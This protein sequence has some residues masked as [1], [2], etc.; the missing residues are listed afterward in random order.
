[1]SKIISFGKSDK[2]LK[3]SNNEDS[4]V[5]KPDIS[6][7]AVADGMGGAASGEVASRIFSETIIEVFSRAKALSERDS[8]DLI[9]NTFRLANEKILSAVKENPQH[10]GM[11]CTAELMVF[12]DES[13]V[14]GHLGDS[15]T[16][17]FRDYKLRQITKDHSLVQE[18]IDKKIITPQEAKTHPLRHVILMAVGIE[19]TLKIDIIKGRNMPGDIFLLCS[20]GLT[21][22]VDDDSIKEVLSLPESLVQKTERLIESAKSAGGNDNITVILCGIV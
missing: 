11:G 4:F 12:Y 10:E 13:Y 3:R 20:D 6:C 16:Y 7:F 2:G 22:M 21:D 19:E 5:V 15:R 14:L 8:F 17:L 9:Q 1:M 18:Q